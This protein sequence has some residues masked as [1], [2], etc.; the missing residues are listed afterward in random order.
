[1]PGAAAALEW[2]CGIAPP[3]DLMAILFEIFSDYV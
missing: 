3:E 2:G 1:L